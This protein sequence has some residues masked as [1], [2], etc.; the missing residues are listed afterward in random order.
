M[1]VGTDFPEIESGLAEYKKIDNRGDL[2]RK[3]KFSAPSSRDWKQKNLSSKEPHI[4]AFVMTQLFFLIKSGLAI[5][6]KKT[7]LQAKPL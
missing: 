2:N 7:E 3:A 1:V 5:G 4:K 6:W